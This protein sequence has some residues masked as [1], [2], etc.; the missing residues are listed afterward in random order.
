MDKWMDNFA[1]ADPS[2]INLDTAPTSTASR[3]MQR[4]DSPRASTWGG[5][6]RR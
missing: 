6:G 5:A 4:A 3:P 2:T 1:I